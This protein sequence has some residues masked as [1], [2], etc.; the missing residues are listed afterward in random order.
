MAIIFPECL[1][2]FFQKPAHDV[3]VIEFFKSPERFDILI[4]TFTYP[5]VRGIISKLHIKKV[6]GYDLR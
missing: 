1:S 6:L 4:I 3:E 2:H 5:E